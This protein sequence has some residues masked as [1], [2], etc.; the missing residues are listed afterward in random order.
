MTRATFAGVLLMFA[1]CFGGGGI[2]P[3]R[4]AFNRGVYLYSVGAFDQA[5]SEYRQALA[6]DPDDHRARFNLGVTLEARGRERAAA[7]DANGA[8]ADRDAAE[9]EYRALVEADRG[10]LRASINLAA[11]E[12]ERGAEDAAIERLQST[13]EQH[14]RETLPRT[15]LAAHLRARGDDAGARAQLDAALTRDPDHAPA[16]L[17]LGDLHRSAGRADAARASFE[18]VLRKHPDDLAAL[19]S[20]GE[21]A[22]ERGDAADA[23]A[24]LQRLLLVDPDHHRGHLA[25]AAAMEQLDDL[26]AATVH[27]WRARALRPTTSAA[28]QQRLLGL[29][30]RL[31]ARERSR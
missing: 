8:A 15:A 20:L 14:P 13:I 5:I 3:I 26:E 24:W 7:G 25:A 18:R 11:L 30:E 31:A 28:L 27:L 19:L 1:A 9:A 17:L 23:A 29:Y 6:D 10:A 16:N 4:T 12:F 21:L 22:L 2:T